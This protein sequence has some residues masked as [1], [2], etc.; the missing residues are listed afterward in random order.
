MRPRMASDFARRIHSSSDGD[1]GSVDSNGGAG[2]VDGLGY[3][4]N[5][6]KLLLSAYSNVARYDFP[7]LFGPTKILSGRRSMDPLAIGPKSDTSIL[8][9]GVTGE[10]TVSVGLD[11]A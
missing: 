1:S 3:R 4:G 5:P 11:S 2:R 6:W 9:V 7:E 8:A 10:S